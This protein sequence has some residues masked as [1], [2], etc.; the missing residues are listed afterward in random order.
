MEK[1]ELHPQIFLIKD[2]LSQDECDQYINRSEEQQFE[3]AKI[4]V[5]GRQLMNKGIRNNDRLMMFDESI[6]EG[7]LKELQNFYLRNRKAIIF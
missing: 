2:F 5:Y 1:K 7:L 6:A 3:E 4:S